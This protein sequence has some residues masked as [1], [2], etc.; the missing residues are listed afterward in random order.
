LEENGQK[1]D[2]KKLIIIIAVV[3]IAILAGVIIWLLIGKKDGGNDSEP[4]PMA[5]EGTVVTDEETA[6]R[7]DDEMAKAAEGYMTL[8]MKLEALS[9]DGENFTCYIGNSPSNTKDMYFELVDDSDGEV[10]YKSNLIQ[11]GYRIEEFKS[12]KKY[13]PGQYPVTVNYYQMED[14]HATVYSEVASA[15]TLIVE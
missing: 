11:V 9:Q 15:I 14:D 1:K 6:R 12:S 10:I 7:I 3:I 4:K 13:E 2:N 5:Y 8:N